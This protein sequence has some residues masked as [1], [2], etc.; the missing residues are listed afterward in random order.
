MLKSIFF[1]V[2]LITTSITMG[3]TTTVSL[4]EYEYSYQNDIIIPDGSYLKDINNTLDR[5]EGT[6]TGSHKNWSYNV[7]L[8]K[9]VNRKTSRG[10]FEDFVTFEYTITNTVSGESYTNVGES[11]YEMFK[12]VGYYNAD[13]IFILWDDPIQQRAGEILFSLSTL[14]ERGAGMIFT[15]YW[16]IY[17]DDEE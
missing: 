10:F 9:H 4:E 3:Q 16:N 14:R 2:T 8:T 5:F 13:N 12:S 17:R 1:Y 11:V 6:Y 7:K 15:N